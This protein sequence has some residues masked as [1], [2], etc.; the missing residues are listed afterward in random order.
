MENWEIQRYPDI[1]QNRRIRAGIPGHC[2][3]FIAICP[4]THT[5]DGNKIPLETPHGTTKTNVKHTLWNEFF[6][7]RRQMNSSNLTRRHNG[8]KCMKLPLEFVITSSK[9]FAQ[10]MPDA[11]KGRPKQM[12]RSVAKWSLPFWQSYGDYILTRYFICFTVHR[13]MNHLNFN[14]GHWLLL[15]LLA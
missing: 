14:P 6:I 11:L 1:K 12:T 10:N 4:H 8:E 3:E 9:Y 2:R 13:L 7:P 5:L 15:C